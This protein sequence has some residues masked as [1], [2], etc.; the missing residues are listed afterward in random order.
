LLYDERSYSGTWPCDGQVP[1]L[2]YCLFCDEGS[3]FQCIVVIKDPYSGTP[4][5]DGGSY[6]GFMMQD[7]YPEHSGTCRFCDEE[8]IGFAMEDLSSG[9]LFVTKDPFLG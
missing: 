6:S 5:C 1:S 4:L 7:H 2:E 8:V 9:A 3:L